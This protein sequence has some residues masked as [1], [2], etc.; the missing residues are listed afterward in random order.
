MTEQEKIKENKKLCKEMPF[1]IPRNRWTDEISDDYDYTYTELSEGGWK[2]LEL[3]FFREITPLL[4]KANYLDKYRI[5]DSKE[6]WG[7]WRLY[8]NGLPKEIFKERDISH[9]FSLN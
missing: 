6:K 2:E 7:E 1:L 5:I 9:L 8:D 3:E 4:K